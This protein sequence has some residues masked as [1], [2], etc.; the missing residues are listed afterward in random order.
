MIKQEDFINN[1]VDYKFG[2]KKVTIVESHNFVLPV[3]A[4]YLWKVT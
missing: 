2:N 4:E 1:R 3:W